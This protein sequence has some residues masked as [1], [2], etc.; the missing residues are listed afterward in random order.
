MGQERKII[1]DKYGVNMAEIIC[2]LS[3]SAILELGLKKIMKN[4]S[5]DNGP[6]APDTFQT[7]ASITVPTN[8][9]TKLKQT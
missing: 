2:N 6:Q 4:P 5:H 3:D 9:Q 7:A 8:K 1:N